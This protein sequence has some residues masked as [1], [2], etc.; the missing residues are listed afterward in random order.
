VQRVLHFDSRTIQSY[1]GNYSAF[2]AARA[3]ALASQQAAYVKQQREIAHLR[4][5]VERFRAKATKARQAQSR[6]K[7]LARM[8][9]IAP[10]HVD[11]TF[12]FRFEAP[13]AAPVPLV[14]L[15]EAELG[16]EER[17]VL[18]KVDISILPGSRIALL[19]RN[20]AGKSTLVRALAG[21]GDLKAGKRIEGRG[22]GIG[23]FAQHQLEQLRSDESPLQHLV[24]IDA[25]AREQELRDF[26]GRFGFSGE[27]ALAAVGR[28]SGGER[29]RLGLALIV[30]SR[31][32]LLLLDEPTNHLDLEMRH[33]LTLALQEYEGA[34]VLVSH[35][36]HLIRTSAD[37]LW[38]VADGRAAP[39]D[40][41][42]EDYQTWLQ[43]K[44]PAAGAGAEARS[45]RKEERRERARRQ[46]ARAA[47]RR[48][49]EN[50]AGALELEIDALALETERIDRDLI[51]AA[52]G[53]SDGDAIAGM[54]RRRAE[55]QV[56]MQDLE[57]RWYALQEA[58]SALD[59]G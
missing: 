36:R 23:Y 33:A 59:S 20:G 13:L 32:N 31:P 24:R 47:Q 5:F 45:S 43:A 49:I 22:L 51:A 6:V 46:D 56:R 41:D 16:Y 34:V 28:F 18:V 19:G 14:K 7:A 27:Q 55:I 17:T 48:P 25:A 10:A 52:Q 2:E 8:E 15:E 54:Q 35:D 11:S 3:A 4:R 57:S 29:S 44:A 21:E 37:E 12:S 26:L 58:L 50:E 40:G 1:G 38:L 30:R 53:A 9:A 39:F 42:L